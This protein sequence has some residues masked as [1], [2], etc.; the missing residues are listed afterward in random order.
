MNW[1]ALVSA[2][3]LCAELFEVGTADR[4]QKEGFGIN[5]GFGEYVDEKDVYKAL[6]LPIHNTEMR[7]KMSGRGKFLIDG[8]GTKRVAESALIKSV[9]L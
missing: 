3:V 6:S 9:C 4:L 2:I 5:L 1:H 8:Q 7:V